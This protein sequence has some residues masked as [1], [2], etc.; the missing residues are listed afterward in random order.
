MYWNKPAPLFNFIMEKFIKSGHKTRCC[1]IGNFEPQKNEQV[2][3]LADLEHNFLATLQEEE[4]SSI[5]RLV[6]STN[7]IIWVTLGGLLRGDTPEC[8]LSLGLART[9]TLEQLSL[10][11]ITVDID[12]KSC[13]YKNIGN[14]LVNI[15]IGQRDPHGPRENEFL[16]DND[17]LYISRLVP[18]K[19]L[20]MSSKN[21]ET[22]A[23]IEQS[24]PLKGVLKGRRILFQHDDRV[25][26]PLQ[27]DQVEVKIAAIGLNQEVSIS[28]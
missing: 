15:A 19:L 22:S 16:F 20:N 5:Q 7:L 13:S 17:K 2:I 23:S 27:K 24:L 11:L 12:P 3:I 4:L 18:D 9:L 14:S 8:A 21:E 6:D 25:T 1:A 28:I 10:D 26:K